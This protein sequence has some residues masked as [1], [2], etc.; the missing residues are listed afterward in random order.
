MQCCWGGGPGACSQCGGCLSTVLVADSGRRRR[1]LHAQLRPAQLKLRCCSAA[2]PPPSWFICLAPCRGVT[3]T[4]Q[5]APCKQIVQY[6]ILVW[7]ILASQRRND[8]SIFHKH[9]FA[10]V[11]KLTMHIESDVWKEQ[12]KGNAMQCIHSTGAGCCIWAPCRPAQTGGGW[13]LLLA[14]NIRFRSSRGHTAASRSL[15]WFLIWIVGTICHLGLGKECQE[16]L[17]SNI[18]FIKNSLLKISINI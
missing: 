6:S 18:F 1:Q 11:V 16:N 2:P 3:P 7:K 14:D 4:R 13:W 5:L 15:V 8:N 17:S 9:L 12:E 10:A